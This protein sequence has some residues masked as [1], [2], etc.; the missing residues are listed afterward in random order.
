MG[1][2]SLGSSF[3][4]LRRRIQTAIKNVIVHS[5]IK[6]HCLLRH[7]AHLLTQR[8]ECYLADILSI[9]ENVSAAYIIKTRQQT[10]DSGLACTRRADEGNHLSRLDIEGNIMQN[11]FAAVIC[12]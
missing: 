10:G 3:N 8:I 7:D 12:K 9:N 11:L 4:L 1:V 2:G 5:T 6:K